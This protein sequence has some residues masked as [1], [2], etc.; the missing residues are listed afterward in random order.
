MHVHPSYHCKCGQS[1]NCEVLIQIV[2]A[3]AQETSNGQQSV[4]EIVSMLDTKDAEIAALRAAA[5]V[6]ASKVQCHMC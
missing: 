1:I 6:D 3:S 4:S 2:Q 5:K